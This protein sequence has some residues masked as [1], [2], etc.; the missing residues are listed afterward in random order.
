MH[1]T[2]PRR[3]TLDVV[4]VTSRT[5]AMVAVA[6]GAV[7][8]PLVVVVEPVWQPRNGVAMLLDSELRRACARIATPPQAPSR[9]SS[10]ERSLVGR[11]SARR[12]DMCRCV[13]RLGLQRL[14]F[15]GQTPDTAFI[16]AV[17][18][19]VALP[20]LMRNQARATK[21]AL[22]AKGLIALTANR[23]KPAPRRYRESPLGW[24]WW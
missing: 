5:R 11:S 22:N 9:R 24:R 2:R 15:T 21:N 13:A 19:N 23:Q 20:A 10:P 1:E 16:D 3:G 18:E 14:I 12:P 17:I 4:P 8:A 6:E 7:G